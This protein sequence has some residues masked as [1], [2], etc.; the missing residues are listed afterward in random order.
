MKNLCQLKHLSCFG[1]CGHDWKSKK[2]ILRQIM[3]NTNSLKELTLEK[4]IKESQ[5]QLSESGGCKSLIFKKEKIVC[6]LHPLQNKGKDFRDKNCKK[7]YFCETFKKFIKWTE[8]KQEKFIRF[9]LKKKIDNYEY[10][11][12]MDSGKFLE[13]FEE[14]IIKN[15]LFSN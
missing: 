12:G 4:F 9:L 15:N 1:C 10:S 13:E 11:I 8:T 2:A 6:A 5:V 7:E 3:K 14:K